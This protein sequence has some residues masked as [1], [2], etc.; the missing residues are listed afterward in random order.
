MVD[1]YE[2]FQSLISLPTLSD[3]ADEYLAAM[4][5]GT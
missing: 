2:R 3:V 1:E 4:G 5:V